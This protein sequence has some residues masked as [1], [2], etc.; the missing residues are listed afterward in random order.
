STGTIFCG[1]I[2]ADY[3]KCGIN[4]MFNTGTVV[5]VNCNIFGSGY[6]RNFIHSFSWGG[7]TGGVRVYDIEKAIEVAEIVQK[8]RN[9][10]MS[11]ED[12]AILRHI[13]RESTRN[14]R[15]G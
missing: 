12:K 6:Q 13:Y 11:D 7:N 9:I 5:G 1:T 10:D 3:S 2:M 15:L 4:T 8:R 14:K